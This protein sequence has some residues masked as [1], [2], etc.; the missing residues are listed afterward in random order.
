MNRFAKLSVVM[1]AVHETIRAYQ[2][3]A[4]E[5]P[6]SAWA[7]AGPLQRSTREAVEFA[8]HD[9]T[10]GAQHEAW[11]AAKSRD[12][13]RYGP[14]KDAEQKTHPSLVPFEQL[15]ANEQRKDALVIAV[16]RALAPVLE[17]EPEGPTRTDA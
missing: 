12:G 15:S 1:R 14:E 13:W 10:P 16:V 2:E 3:A 5:Q 11:A 6:V 17:L 7:D 4:G 8:L 9:P